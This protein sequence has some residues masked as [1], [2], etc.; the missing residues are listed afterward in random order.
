MLSDDDVSR[1]DMMR[2]AALFTAA[3]AAPFLRA[4]EARAQEPDAPVRIGYLPITDATP[5][6]VAHGKGFFEAEGL[7][8]DK[9]VLLRSWAQVLEAFISGQVNVVHLLSP[10]TIWARFGS[11]APAKVV[12]WNH[13]GGSGLT[14]A[15]GIASVKD[16]G[17]KTVAIPFWYSIHNV[18]LQALFREN[19]LK[20]VTKKASP[21]PDEVNLVI[22]A[23]SDMV[24]ALGSG[25]IAGYI[26]AE[27]FNAAAEALGVGKVLRF[28]GDVWK[29]HACCV[30]FMHERDLSQRPDWSQKVVDAMVKAQLW[31]RQ[32]R[33]ETAAL[34]SK[35]DPNRYTP[36]TKAVLEKVLAPPQTDDAAYVASGAIRNPAWRERRI[37]FQPYPFPSYTE[38]LVRQ[39]KGTLIESER[40]FLADLDPAFAARDLVDDSFVKK[41]LAKRGGLAA[42]GL[43]ESF[44]R[45]EVISA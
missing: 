19:G 43:A 44:Q 15:P 33:A 45:D 27:P 39:L 18:V 42:F 25:Q 12:A 24:P 31:T 8:A 41:A 29:D 16:L 32:N 37:D 35:D 28:T 1:R 2:L 36:H 34:L 23:P 30:V 11:K 14:A 20:P 5:L 4:Y 40:G 21:A 9:P 6:L 3:G 10:M 7:K 38:E 26:V 13:T 17:G 22:M